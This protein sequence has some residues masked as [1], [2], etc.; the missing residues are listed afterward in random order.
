[1][2]YGG[3]VL[4]LVQ[5]FLLFVEFDVICGVLGRR[6]IYIYVSKKFGSVE[7]MNRGFFWRSF[8][9]KVFFVQKFFYQ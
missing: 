8:I 6:N 1:M 5:E 3:K 4:F 7:F 9:L 2:E